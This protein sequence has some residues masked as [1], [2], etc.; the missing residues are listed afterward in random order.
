MS[1]MRGHKEDTACQQDGDGLLSEI[2]KTF[3]KMVG[4]AN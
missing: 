2:V 4:L 3:K 1:E